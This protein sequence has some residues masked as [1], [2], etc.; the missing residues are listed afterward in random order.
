MSVSYLFDTHKQESA[1]PKPQLHKMAKH[2]QM[3]LG[4]KGLINNISHPRVGTCLFETIIRFSYSL[5]MSLS[6]KILKLF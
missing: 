2:I 1:S 5:L 6:K 4:L 3:G